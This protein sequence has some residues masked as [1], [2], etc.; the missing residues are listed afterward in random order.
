GTQPSWL[1]QRWPEALR[2]KRSLR[3]QL[4]RA[5]AKGVTVRVVASAELRDPDSPVR[6]GMTA[7]A[8]R[9]LE[10][11]PMAP[12][13]FLVQI[14][15]FSSPDERCVLVAERDGAVVG[16]LSAVP[17]YG[18]E[19][20]FFEDVLRHP[21]APNG[22]VELL[23]DHA[24]REVAA[25]GSCHVTLGMVPLDGAP[26]S[27]LRFIRDHT[28]WLYDFEGLRS[29]KAKL[30]PERWDPVFLAYPR[31][32]RGVRAV[33]DSL[34]AF[35]RGSLI[36]FGLATLHHRAAAVT[37]LLAVLLI[38]WTLAMAVSDT[39]RWFPS[40]EIKT[41]WIA[42]DLLLFILLMVLASRWNRR[43]ATALAALAGADFVLGSVQAALY[44][45]PGAVS[46]L[47]WVVIA[48]ALAAPLFATV[49][50]WK[51]RN[52]ATLY[53]DALHKLEN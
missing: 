13:G 44:N 3:E 21:E 36:R 45:G 14:D 26:S 53:H 7:L 2:K 28:R 39:A 29:F 48:L 42:L 24:M 43:L 33:L 37:R 40:S 31:A 46:W 34:A 5:R 20:W 27:V 22:V 25:R 11:R 1:P 18:R 30:L 6:R 49:F 10:G 23:F 15:L 8:A 32:E 9:W 41:A 51:C 52:R 4:R 38:P 19:G 12:M 50:L 17:V 16:V 35:A 47:D